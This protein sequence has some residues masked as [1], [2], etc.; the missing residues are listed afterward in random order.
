MDR[1]IQETLAELEPRLDAGTSCCECCMFWWQGAPGVDPQR[2]Q[3][4]RY[5]PRAQLLASVIPGHVLWPETGP[6]DW[7]GEHKDP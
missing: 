5:A 3:C 4:R 1:Q 6:G 7:C 2:G